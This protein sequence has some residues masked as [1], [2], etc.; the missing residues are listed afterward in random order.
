MVVHPRR[1][2]DRGRLC[3]IERQFFDASGQLHI[4]VP[5]RVA[6]NQMIVDVDQSRHHPSARGIDYLDICKV[7]APGDIRCREHFC[8]GIAIDDNCP[9]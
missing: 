2:A 7:Y 3:R 8:D 9:V 6:E 1:N 5:N 4:K